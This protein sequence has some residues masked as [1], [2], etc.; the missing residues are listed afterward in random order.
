MLKI[1]KQ[2][3]YL[4]YCFKHIT[5][6][7]TLFCPAFYYCQAKYCVHTCFNIHLFNFPLFDMLRSYNAVLCTAFI[8]EIGQSMILQITTDR[9]R[10]KHL[11][12]TN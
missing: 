5:V 8:I 3:K 7:N 6:S 11:T 10:S 1:L 12:T 9:M 4:N 2:D